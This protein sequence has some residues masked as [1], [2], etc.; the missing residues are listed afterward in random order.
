MHTV[1]QTDNQGDIIGV[2]QVL[3]KQRGNFDRD[4]EA[5]LVGLTEHI[6]Q[7]IEKTSLY[8]E[9]KPPRPDRL[10]DYR[11]NFIVG[12][13]SAMRQVYELVDTARKMGS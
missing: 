2:L 7:V 4:D 5:T 3:N 9:L 13:S 10:I 6:G 1:T 12:T 8:Q 11:Y